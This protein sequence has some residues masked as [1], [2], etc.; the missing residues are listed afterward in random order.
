MF[1]IPYGET[2]FRKLRLENN[3]YM[4]KT[5]FQR[6]SEFARDDSPAKRYFLQAN[7][8]PYGETNLRN[9]RIL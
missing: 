8:I 6:I 9:R 1:N 5:S 2:N 4:D 3:L 7:L